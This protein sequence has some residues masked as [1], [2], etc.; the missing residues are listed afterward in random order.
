MLWLTSSSLQT[1]KRP[2]V[3]TNGYDKTVMGWSYDSLKRVK[4]RTMELWL[5]EYNVWNR[6]IWNCLHHVEITWLKLGESL[7]HVNCMCIF[8]F[9]SKIRGWRFGLIDWIKVQLE[10]WYEKL[11]AMQVQLCFSLHMSNKSSEEIIFYL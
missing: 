7:L 2:N 6:Y 9:F 11:S 5:K 8:N 10:S 1:S 4:H 3:Q